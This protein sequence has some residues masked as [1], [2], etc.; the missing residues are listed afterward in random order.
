MWSVD[1][2]AKNECGHCVDGPRCRSNP[3]SFAGLACVKMRSKPAC[4]DRDGFAPFVRM[5]WRP[6]RFGS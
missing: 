6:R 2:T 4:A 5:R 1:L 3:T